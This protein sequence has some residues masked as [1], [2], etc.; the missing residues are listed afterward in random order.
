MEPYAERIRIS[1]APMRVPNTGWKTQKRI[2]IDQ[3]A[4]EINYEIIH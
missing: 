1:W 2:N 4:I 3:A